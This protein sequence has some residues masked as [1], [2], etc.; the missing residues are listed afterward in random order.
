LVVLLVIGGVEQNPGPGVEDESFMQVM[1]SGCNR[2]PKLGTQC[3]TCGHWFHH[4]CKNVQLV[5]SGKW[6]YERCKWKRLCLLEEKLQNALIQIKHL[7][8]KKKRLEEQLQVV[9]TGN[10]IGSHDMVQEHHEGEQRLVVGDSIIRNV[11]TGQNNMK[12]ECFPGIRTKQLHRIL[13]N[14]DP[15]YSYNSRTFVLVT[16]VI[17]W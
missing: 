6:N 13:D 1:C 9:A 14:R 17:I 12:A 15:R 11:G 2:S 5:D 7:K 3:D 4:S 16:S 10:K 8:L